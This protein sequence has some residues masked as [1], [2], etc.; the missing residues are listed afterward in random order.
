MKKVIFTLVLLNCFTFILAQEWAPV[1]TKWYYTNVVWWGGPVT[2]QPNIIECVG[3]TIINSRACRI[4]QGNCNCSFSS[5]RNYMYSENDKIFLFNDTLN[6]FHVLYDFTKGTGETWTVVPPICSDSF[7]V[8][9]DSIYT[10]VILGHSYSIQHV[11]NYDVGMINWEFYGEVVRGIGNISYC[12]FPPFAT[13]DP[14]T[15]PLRCFESPDTLIKFDTFPCDTT[16][17][18][19]SINEN[20][21]NNAMGISP[22]PFTTSTQIT[23]DNTYHNISLAV[24]DIQGKLMLQSQYKD[25]SQIQ[26]NRDGLN[27]GMYFLKLILDERWVETGKIV[28]SE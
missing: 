18:A 26:L 28:V 13:C 24:Y 9:V 8:I 2:Y 12:L 11:R 19:L 16:I 21:I 6:K 23:L 4:I 17:T 22:N 7:K 14:Y 3:D 20:K 27:N 10:R 1:G 15:G 5:G 25:C